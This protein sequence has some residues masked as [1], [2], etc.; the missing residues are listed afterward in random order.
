MAELQPTDEFLV[1][2]NDITYTQETDTL[3]A[4]LETTDYLLVNRSDSTY[5]ITGEDF[6]NSVI[7]PLEVTV[8]I[9][10][11]P[12]LI[13]ENAEAIPVVTGGK[14]PD[15]GYVFTYQW[16]Y[17][18][19]L[20]GTNQIDI[21]GQTASTY[22][23]PE[24][25]ITKFIGCTVTTTDA[26]NTTATGT[27]YGGPV[28]AVEIAP[29]IDEVIL[30]EIFD[31][32]SRYTDKQFPYTTVMGLDGTPDP[33]YAVKAKL[34]G[35][36]FNFAVESDTITKVEG[37]GT[38]VYSTDTIANVNQTVDTSTIVVG[39]PMENFSYKPYPDQLE[40]KSVLTDAGL[41]LCMASPGW[42]AQN[43]KDSTYENSP[44]IYANTQGQKMRFTFTNADVNTLYILHTSS[45]TG[46]KAY[47]YKL[48]G[49]VT[50]TN[51]IETQS[52]E[53]GSGTALKDENTF[54]VTQANGYLEIEVGSTNSLMIH[55][56]S[57]GTGYVSEPILTF[58]TA[59]NFDRFE[60]GDVV[61]GSTNITIDGNSGVFTTEYNR[62]PQSAF[63]GDHLTMC[64]TGNGDGVAI[65]NNYTEMLFDPPVDV[66]STINMLMYSTGH[67]N[68][69]SING[70]AYQ[71]LDATIAPN[72]SFTG[73]LNSIRWSVLATN[74]AHGPSGIGFDD[75]G[76]I[77]KT[78]DW[79]GEFPYVL[80]GNAA[81]ITA[82]DDTV[83]S[84]TVDGGS[85]AGADGTGDAGD[86]RFEPAQEWSNNVIN[87]RPSHPASNAF[88]GSTTTTWFANSSPAY[89]TP[90]TVTFDE[91]S[92]STLRIFV[93]DRGTSTGCLVLNGSLDV[94]NQLGGGYEWYTITGVTTLSS[95]TIKSLSATDYSAIRAVE[96]DGKLLVDTSIPGGQGATDISKSIDYATKLTVASDKDLNVITG[97]IYMT[98]G[99][100]KQD[101]SGVLEPAS[102]TLQTSEI[103]SVDNPPSLTDP[104]RYTGQ[105]QNG[106]TEQ[107]VSAIQ[108]IFSGQVSTIVYAAVNETTFTYT[109]PPD[110]K[111]KSSI[112][113]WSSRNDSVV[114]AME[115]NNIDVF[116]QI[117]VGSAPVLA[118]LTEKLGTSGTLSSFELTTSNSR[119]PGV[120][121]FVLDDEILYI[122]QNKTTLTFNSPNPDLQYFQVGDVVQD[123]GWNQSAEW[124]D[125]AVTTGNGGTWINKTNFFNGDLSNF[126]HANT[127][128]S[129]VEVTVSFNPPI[130]VSN[131]VTFHGVFGGSS[132]AVG[133]WKVNNEAPIDV[134]TDSSA[135]PNSQPNDY[136]FSGLV[137]SISITRDDAASSV[138]G[139]YCFGLAVDD[140]L[141]VDASVSNP[142]TV[143][144][145][146]TDTTANTM[147]VDGGSWDTSNLSEV[148]SNQCTGV[149]MTNYPATNAFMGESGATN[150]PGNLG[151]LPADGETVT[152]TPATPLTGNK[153][154]L[155]LFV[156]NGSDNSEALKING[157]S[158]ISPSL[159]FGTWYNQE[160]NL[161]DGSL[162]SISMKR[163][164]ASA[165][166]VFIGQ[167]F[168][169]GVEYIDKGI[170]EPG[171]TSVTGGPYTA[172]G[173]F[174][175]A[176]GTEVSLSA[177]SGRW[178]ANNKAGIPF[179]FV[180]ATPTVDTAD[181]VW[182]NLQIINDKAQVMGIQR[183]DPGFLNVTNKDY[184]VQFPSVFATGQ[185]PD[186]DLPL[187]TAISVIV[188]AENDAG[189]SVKESNTLLPQIPNPDGAAGPITD[190]EGAGTNVYTTD[191]I[192]T[193]TP[194][195]V[196]FNSYNSAGADLGPITLLGNTVQTSDLVEREAYTTIEQPGTTN[197]K[198]VNMNLPII[199][200]PGDLWVE[201]WFY[202]PSSSWKLGYGTNRF[203][204]TLHSGNGVT[205]ADCAFWG[206]SSDSD[207]KI[208]SS[209]TMSAMITATHNA[210]QGWHH[211]AFFITGTS[212]PRVAAWFDGE[213]KISNYTC[214]RGAN[215]FQFSGYNNAYSNTQ[216]W[217]TEIGGV[218]VCD[219]NPYGAESFTPTPVS[220]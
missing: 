197:G 203:P 174:L 98:D 164:D 121:A 84:I 42:T 155:N 35:S 65:G 25:D 100:P 67:V 81:S 189:A 149:A 137:S 165:V 54:N 99:T 151:W 201:L 47:T 123:G 10:P 46:A 28:S 86:G 96:V 92:V 48:T 58:P 215:Q 94:S 22:V 49:D 11:N 55:Y 213:L 116:Q 132:S 36:T 90:S 190:V 161:D 50:P 110:I 176:N 51:G 147:T 72:V 129:S 8:I 124:S 200:T 141:L 97:D 191:T 188:K 4:S 105:L 13:R 120:S 212:D 76:I 135:S 126:A 159:T 142:D 170:R 107:T 26:L 133:T 153:V 52:G 109:F 114:G 82:I 193:V 196:N 18:D 194:G 171:D 138:A 206:Y 172:E 19:D 104:S 24:S 205:L 56:M 95:I 93:E 85:W 169:D 118:D 143:K 119:G 125:N 75:S 192:S 162:T 45:G 179:S 73:T 183:D 154:T 152:F 204:I 20:L 60:V 182:G 31:G 131:K 91:I 113:V 186:D 83:P 106:G 9:A 78:I 181:Q 74:R 33:T 43:P 148:W 17:A 29:V 62:G 130:R 128:A 150:L 122:P 207:W 217:S 3:M 195:S 144:V 178:I 185:E 218:R 134:N 168:I 112:K 7:D 127:N 53:Q 220:A 208:L 216:V 71:S 39:S 198:L 108:K 79:Q 57:I 177:S 140:K 34:S 88:D 202:K 40:T 6:I 5:K 68:H 103:A 63:D 32:E 214:T 219:N 160:F 15:G 145:I 115:V 87:N 41:A 59:N 173:T 163:I 211:L 30:T 166:H 23:V 89:N 187:G 139:L 21:P 44:Y 27:G 70:G 14:Q 80:D 16:H 61:Q 37:A 199:N 184:S 12:P 158:V 156:Q 77:T 111:W 69:I 209:P 175:E 101:G 136:P 117:V 2:R 146:S 102:Y 210:A 180:P 1:N 66:E 64:S 38:D 157:A 167:I